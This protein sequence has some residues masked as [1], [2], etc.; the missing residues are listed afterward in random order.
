MF[1]IRIYEEDN[2][3]RFALENLGLTDK[4]VNLVAR[5]LLYGVEANAGQ[6]LFPS[7][8]FNAQP[9]G[10]KLARQVVCKMERT[11]KG[12]Q[13]L[14]ETDGLPLI[15]EAFV[16]QGDKME[17]NPFFTVKA[18]N[19]GLEERRAKAVEGIGDSLRYINLRS[20]KG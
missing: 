10:R 4:E 14:Q 8:M 9:E 1:K 17:V 12:R 13:V 18:R 6:T 5:W 15:E 7:A 11:Q 2:V 19:S 3:K 16:S 20:R